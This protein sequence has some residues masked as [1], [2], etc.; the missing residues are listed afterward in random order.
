MGLRLRSVS[1]QQLRDT[2]NYSYYEN[3]FNHIVNY[4][5]SGDDTRFASFC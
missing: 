5:D 4:I 1:S 3:S 2:S